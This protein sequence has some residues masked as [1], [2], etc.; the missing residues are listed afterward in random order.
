MQAAAANVPQGHESG[1]LAEAPLIQSDVQPGVRTAA[2]PTLTPDMLGT[3]APVA[4][5]KQVLLLRVRHDAA[6]AVQIEIRGMHL[7]PGTRL[8][9][10]GAGNGAAIDIAGPWEGTGPSADGSFWTPAVRGSEA[11]LELQCDGET[12]ADLP[13]EIVQTAAADLAEPPQQEA[14][15]GPAEIRTSIFRGIPLKHEV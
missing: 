10:Y 12:P 1:A 6:D 14:V 8:F 2:V 7:P 3:F 9:V 4:N 15:E 11:I 13:F 5:G